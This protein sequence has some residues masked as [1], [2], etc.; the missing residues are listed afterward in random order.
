MFFPA[1]PGAARGVFVDRVTIA[2]ATAKAYRLDL[3]P[4]LPHGREISR[5]LTGMRRSPLATTGVDIATGIYT[6]PVAPELAACLF[7]QHIQDYM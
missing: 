1:D 3:P 5:R 7:R 6:N 4:E 2:G